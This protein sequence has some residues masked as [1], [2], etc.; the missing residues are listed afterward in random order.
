MSSKLFV[1][2]NGFDLNLGLPT[3][4]GDFLKSDNFLQH[5][6]L[7]L[8]KYLKAVNES[9][10]WIDIEAELVKYSL[11]HSTQKLLD[12]SVFL[13][14]YK[15][16]NKSLMEYILSIN[17]M[18][19]DEKSWAYQMVKDYYSQE[20]S[21]VVSFNY[22]NSFDI[23]LD[24]I[25]GINPI[26]IP[27]PETQFVH[28]EAK[29]GN[30]IFGVDDSANIGGDAFLYKSTSKHFNGKEIVNLLQSSDEIY[31]FGHSLGESDHM[32]FRNFFQQCW[33][34]QISNR[35][36]IFYPYDEQGHI[37]LHKQLQ[38]LT[39]RN[40]SNLKNL[41]DISCRDSSQSIHV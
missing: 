15:L 31:I 22:T 37:D 26:N 7:A 32:Y 16:L 35:K 8:F 2:G 28:G 39:Q 5:T 6:N 4:Y 9:S 17:I 21:K 3:S 33:T 27:A 25:G 34:G 29:K 38:I 30:I 23:I 24:H 18:Q 19:I 12:G 13:D 11:Q 10:R 14:E 1:I 41:N 40:V 36:I 20:D